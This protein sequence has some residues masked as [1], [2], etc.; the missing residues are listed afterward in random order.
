MPTIRQNTSARKLRRE[1]SRAASSLPGNASACRSG[2]PARAASPASLVHAAFAAAASFGYASSA[3]CAAA[4]ASALLSAFAFSTASASAWRPV[5][6][7]A[8]NPLRLALA[9]SARALKIPRTSFSFASS[10]SCTSRAVTFSSTLPYT[11]CGSGMPV[12]FT[13]SQTTGIM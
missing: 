1:R 10:M 2:G 12:C 8:G 5:S 13:D 7:L 9:A 4:T 11:N 3:F 6:K